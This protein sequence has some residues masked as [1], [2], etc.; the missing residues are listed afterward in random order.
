[1]VEPRPRVVKARVRSLYTEL[2]GG[3]WNRSLEP[4]YSTEVLV[5]GLHSASIQELILASK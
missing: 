5:C 3:V 4:G 2:E 1:M